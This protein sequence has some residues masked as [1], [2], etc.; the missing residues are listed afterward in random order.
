MFFFDCYPFIT[1]GKMWDNSSKTIN[2]KIT[3]STWN[4]EFELP[5]SSYSVS[6]I[7]DYIEYIMKKY[8]TFSTN[9][10]VHIHIH[11]INNRLIFKLKDGYKLELKT[12][13]NIK[14]FGTSNQLIN[15]IN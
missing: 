5:D 12:P 10:P 6:G 7:Q 11:R 13:E 2:P 1:R 8:E 14:L 3:V 9:P 4:D 15:L